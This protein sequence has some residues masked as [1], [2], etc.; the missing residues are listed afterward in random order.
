MKKLIITFMALITITACNTTSNDIQTYT[1][2]SFATQGPIKLNVSKVDVVSEFIP[3]FTR[4][5]VEHLFPVSIEKTARAWAEDRL[6]PTNINSSK[7][8]ILTIK[9]ASVVEELIESEKLLHKDQL[10]YTAKLDIELKIKDQNNLSSA[11]TEI[12]AWRE[13]TIP[14]DTPLAQKEVYWNSMVEK[15]F[16]EFNTQMSQNI[17]EYLDQ[18][19][20]R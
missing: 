5:N 11:Q 16:S 4:P 19:I 3:T 13:L 14:F 17:N 18:Y 7:E 8:A 12:R 6:E 1:A 9:N 20:V 2:P 15:L 10:K